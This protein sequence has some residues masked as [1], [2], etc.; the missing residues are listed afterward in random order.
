M[1]KIA[2]TGPESTAKSSLAQFLSQHFGYPSVPEFA[3]DYLQNKPHSYQCS[4][5]EISAIALEQIKLEDKLSDKHELIFCDTDVLVCKIWQ[6]FV[7]G[8]SDPMIE[9]LYIKSTYDLHLL[10]SPDI[11]W[12]YDTQRSNPNDRDILFGKYQNALES[13]SKPYRIICGQGMERFSAAIAFVEPF[14]K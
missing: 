12:E 13:A 3:R 8:Y 10:C 4:F 1:K 6:E 7:F 5:E 9:E 11:E 2:I 14:L